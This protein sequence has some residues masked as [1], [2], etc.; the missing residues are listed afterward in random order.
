MSRLEEQ[1]DP[2]SLI[3]FNLVEQI[4]NLVPLCPAVRNQGWL[5]LKILS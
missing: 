5:I 3:S 1:K 4:S 2:I